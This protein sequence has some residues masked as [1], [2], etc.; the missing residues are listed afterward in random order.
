[1]TTTITYGE[2]IDTIDNAISDFANG[3]EL[4]DSTVADITFA[5]NNDLQ[6]RDYLIGLPINHGLGISAGFINELSEKVTPSER[7]AYD[8]VNAMYHYELKNI[9]ACKTLIDSAEDSNPDYN[10]L[11]L[12]KRVIS[13]EWPSNSLTQMRVQLASSV[14]E[15][16]ADNSDFVIGEDN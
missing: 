10:L 12:M 7:F 8:T 11:K 4:A 13:A 16:I 2:A 9:E 14:A 3:L 5:V 15:Y 6:M 1:M